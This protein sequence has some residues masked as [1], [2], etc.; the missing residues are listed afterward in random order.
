MLEAVQKD[1]AYQASLGKQLSEL[2][3]V[4][5]IAEEYK[6]WLKNNQAQHT[7]Q[8]K[9]YYIDVHLVP[10]FGRMMSIISILCLSNHSFR[11]V[12][13]NRGGRTGK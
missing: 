11:S 2:D 13:S 3:T 5:W 8:D 9:T 1:L 7:L 12:S 6:K 10:F 4:S